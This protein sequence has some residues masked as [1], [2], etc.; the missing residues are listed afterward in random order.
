[1]S[2]SQLHRINVIIRINM[3]FGRILQFHA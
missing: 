2:E 3:I 1:M